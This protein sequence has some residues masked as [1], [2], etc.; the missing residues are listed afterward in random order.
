VFD[1]EWGKP[2]SRCVLQLA[3]IDTCIDNGEGLCE[4]NSLSMRLLWKE[5][6]PVI[7]CLV[8]IVLF[9]CWQSNG[10]SDVA[11]LSNARRNELI[12]MD[13]LAIY[14]REHGRLKDAQAVL[15]E[16]I[17]EERRSARPSRLFPGS[18]K[19]LARLRQ[20]NNPSEAA[21]LLKEA[22]EVS[23]ESNER[24]DVNGS[25]ELAKLYCSLL[26]YQEADRMYSHVINCLLK[27]RAHH[28]VRDAEIA[29]YMQQ[30][31]DVLDKLHRP[32]EANGRR[33]D[34]KELTPS[35]PAIIS[36]FP[37]DATIQKL[38]QFIREQKR[39]ATA[40]LHPL[41]GRRFRRLARSQ[42]PK[43]IKEFYSPG[44]PEQLN[45]ALAE[46]KEPWQFGCIVNGT[47]P[48][49]LAWAGYS[50][51][52]YVVCYISGGFGIGSYTDIFEID[53]TGSTINSHQHVMNYFPTF[54]Q[55]DVRRIA[56]AHHR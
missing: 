53:K 24:V 13:R 23:E 5:T 7:L 22:V 40:T 55:A 12:E 27:E 30:H 15:A 56:T 51:K 42:F 34:A 19:Q 33:Y 9:F 35:R 46:A 47:P 48:R 32:F 2:D 31:A 11:I 29:D 49:K 45:Q 44:Y 17:E 1:T 50:N 52:T 43:C 8:S 14:Y 16:S 41:N 38:N 10:R 28:K 6:S 39:K 4:N 18:L 26:R 25:I 20:Q 21:V 37:D 36:S 3:L 54:V